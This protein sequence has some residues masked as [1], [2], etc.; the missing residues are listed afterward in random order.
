MIAVVREY[1]AS[2]SL[3]E[4]RLL[5]AMT[6]IAL[7]LL[8]YLI[9][10]MPLGRAYDAALED[11]LEAVDRNGRV[12]AMVSAARTSGSRVPA[13]PGGAE[14][15][16]VVT[17]AATQLGLTVDSNSPAGPN[18]VTIG[19]SQA[20]AGAAVGLLRDFESRGIRVEDLR[21]TPSGDGTVSMT[22]RLVR[23]G[24]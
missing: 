12:R 3:R 23:A 5:L 14:I 4:R 2:R 19:I 11:Q 7:P 22:A 15:A 10:I 13:P 21:M 20:R 1:Y 24:G 16:L 6:A 17:E 8:L 9:V 18:A